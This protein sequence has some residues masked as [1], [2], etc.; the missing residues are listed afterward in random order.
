LA[1]WYQRKELKLTQARSK[2]SFGWSHQ[3]QRKVL[4]GWQED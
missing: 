2:L 4:N 1:V 3:A